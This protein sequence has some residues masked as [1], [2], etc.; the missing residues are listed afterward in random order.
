MKR[1]DAMTFSEQV[2]DMEGMKDDAL[3]AERRLLESHGWT[4][5]CATPGSTWLYEKKISDGR[6]LLVNASTAI[7]VEMDLQGDSDDF[8]GD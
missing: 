8:D 4:Y 5:T 2:R 3:A 7:D 6:T 1:S